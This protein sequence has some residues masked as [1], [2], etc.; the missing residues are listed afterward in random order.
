MEN[1]AEIY[2]LFQHS[3]LDNLSETEIRVSDVH[4]ASLG[5]VEHT[6]RWSTFLKDLGF[7][8]DLVF[9]GDH[10]VA[11]EVFL[12]YSDFIKLFKRDGPCSLLR[13]RVILRLDG[14]VIC[15]TLYSKHIWIL[16]IGA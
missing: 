8:Y 11:D 15:P 9:S 14:Q 3:F 4:A 16:K 13:I 5:K 12:G 10:L 2:I 6:G 7:T 1:L